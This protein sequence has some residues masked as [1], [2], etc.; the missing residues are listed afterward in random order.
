M[1]SFPPPL[2]LHNTLPSHL[3]TPLSLPVTSPVPLARLAAVSSPPHADAEE[4]RSRAAALQ[5]C[6]TRRALRRG[7]A[8]H[9]RL[10]RSGLQPDAFLHGTLLNMYC[11]CGRLADA[12]RVFDGMPH[13]DVVAWTSMMSGHT[14][15]GDAD[16]A[17]SLFARMGT[18][19]EAYNGFALAAALKACTVASDLEFTRQVHSQTVKLQQDLYDP[20]V[21][22]S[23]VEAY[24]SSGEVDM[25]ERALLG[26]PVRSDVSWNALLN[27][28]ARHGDYRKVMLVIEKLV[29]S[30][31]EISKY[32]LPT[33][34]KCCMELGLAKS[35][36]AVHALVIKRGLETDSVLS[37]C[38]IE[39]YAKCLSAEDAY[40]V[41]GRIDEPDVVHC[42]GMISCF[43][44]YGMA[45]E[46]FELFVQMVDWGV[47]PNQYTLVGIAAVA[48]KTSDLNLC[49]SIHAHI[50][51]S[52]FAM[53]KVV[54]DAILNMYVKVGA[55]QDAMVALDFIHEPD[56]L[57]WNTLLSAFYSGS[58]CEQG[59][60]IFKKMMCEGVLANKYTF[61]GI[62]RCCTSLMDL[63]YG[64]Q[65]HAC[66][67]KSGMGRDT[68]ISR[69]LVDMYAQ[70]GCFASARLVFDRLKET[71]VFSWAV[72]M[73][74]FA[75]TDEGEKVIEC[76]RS[77]LQENIKP[78]DATLA[79]S[80]SV[81]SDLALLGC[82]LQLH[83]WAIK[84][85]WNNSVVSSALVDMYVK[86]GSITDAE[87]LFYEPETRDQIAWNTIICGYS[88]HGHAYKA[89]EAF[90]VMIDEGNRPDKITFVGVLSACTHEGLLDEGRKYFKLMS[91]I[92]GIT[93]ALEHYACMVDL[94]AKAGKLPEAESLIEQMPL[95]PDAS[96]WRTILGACR[97]HRNIEI[98]ERAAAKLFEIDPDDISSCILLS[99]IYAD[100]RRW[101]DVTRLRNMLLDRGVKKEPGC[102][103]I[104][105]NGQ[106]H[107]FLSQD[108]SSTY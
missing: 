68:D 14:A 95:A 42:S 92:Y 19:G 101:S 31:D 30:G 57:S 86:C 61:V 76:F 44:Q 62:L 85:G 38:L 79:I 90:Q 103:W 36:Q 3:S 53:I 52:G 50:L 47:E 72:I 63:R 108:G 66:V 58:D 29:A 40:K 99:N 87:M 18:E 56:T 102:S 81:C 64:C 71:D 6:A 24:V 83:S 12:R 89:L 23:L 45:W 4:L 105:I 5:D 7:Q 88:H 17:L 21:G 48:S 107:V 97:I 49:R 78:N 84:S 55:A 13:R 28:Y 94:L 98:A 46:A 26:L 15:E 43:D 70:S 39:M 25:A 54:G 80:L 32:T 34:L 65:V 77:M 60:T 1:A 10:L 22:S 35:G 73:S 104:E 37:S 74:G 93:P 51:K 20:Y 9:A 16:E 2:L 33:V 106:I 27:G 11:K 8:L 75:K 91:S 96:L 41:F 82:G 59:L 67:L 69:I 100:L